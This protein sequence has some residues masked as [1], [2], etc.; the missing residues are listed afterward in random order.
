MC[1]CGKSIPAKQPIKTTTKGVSK[2]NKVI[3]IRT[4]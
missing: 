4:K 3:K 1:N 2:P